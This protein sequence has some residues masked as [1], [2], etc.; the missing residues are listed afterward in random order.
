MAELIRS[1]TSIPEVPCSNPGLAVAPL[2]KVL[3]PH[4]LPFRRRLQAVGPVYRRV[5]NT[6][7]PMHLKEPTSVLAKEQGEIPV[8]KWSDSQTYGNR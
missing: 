8:V 5:T 4:C 3:Y 6:L 7:G 1:Q 2:G